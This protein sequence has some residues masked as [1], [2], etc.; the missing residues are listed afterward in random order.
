MLNFR[1]V[2]NSEF[3]F[4]AKWCLGGRLIRSEFGAGLQGIFGLGRTGSF[5]EGNRNN[6]DPDNT[7]VHSG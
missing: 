4:P 7:L 3:F 5:R 2:T 6:L 1:G